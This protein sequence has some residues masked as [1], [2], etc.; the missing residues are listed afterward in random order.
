M[1]VLKFPPAPE[2]P[3]VAEKK[4][5]D[6]EKQKQAHMKRFTDIAV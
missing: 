4:I 5:I 1:T 3:T 6:A 2:N